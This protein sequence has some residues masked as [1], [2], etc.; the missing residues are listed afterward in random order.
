MKNGFRVYDADTHVSPSAEVLERYVDPG[1]RPRL[2]ELTPYRQASDGG[3]HH[4][5]FGRKFYRRVLGEAAPRENFTGRESRWAVAS[6]RGRECR[7]IRPKTA[8]R[9]WTTRGPTSIS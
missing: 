2:A 5:T 1:F 8:S 4:Y 3:L 7:T 6:C 9:T